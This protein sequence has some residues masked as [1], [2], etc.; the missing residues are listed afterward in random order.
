MICILS[1]KKKSRSSLTFFDG[2]SSFFYF[3]KPEEVNVYWKVLIRKG[4]KREETEDN[5]MFASF[6]S[7]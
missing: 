4:Q 7:L 3:Y 2:L 1:Q 5:S 6:M